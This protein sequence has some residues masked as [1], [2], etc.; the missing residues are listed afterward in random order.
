MKRKVVTLTKKYGFTVILVSIFFLGFLVRLYK[1]NTPLA[2]WHS[3]RQVDTASVTKILLEDGEVLRPKYLD[4]SKVQ[5]GYFNPQGLRFVEFPVFNIIHA[6]LYSLYPQLGIEVWGRL[7]SIFSAMLTSV[8]VFLIGKR[9]KNKWL[10]FFAATYYLL[11]PYNVYFTRVILPDPLSVMFAVSSVYFFWGYIDSKKLTPLYASSILFSLAVLTKPHAIFFAIP[12]AYLALKKFGVKKI[13]TN[14]PLLIAL[15]IALIPVFLWR[16][17]MGRPEH[18]AGIP[19][20]TWAFNGDGIR[21][22]P[23]FWRWIFGERIGKLILGIWGLIPFAVGLVTKSKSKMHYVLLFSAFLYLSVFATSNVRHDYYQLF[24]M[25][26]IVIVLALGTIS[27]LSS[28]HFE[29]IPSYTLY[30]I[31]LFLM[32]GIGLFSIRGNYNINDPNMIAAGQRADELLPKDARVIA[33]Y[34]GNTAFLYQVNRL[35]WPIV[36]N[37]IE[38]MMSIG[39]QYYVSTSLGDADTTKFREKFEVLEETDSYI[40]INLQ[41]SKQ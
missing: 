12:I 11:I 26:A 14:I 4:I 40:I 30:F 37:S 27:L 28:K 34:N 33:P 2:D 18:L 19:H 21:F 20:V 9:I 6:T 22:R 25:P 23:A 1:I 39:A 8:F 17:W 24:I 41:N 5:T 38:H 29:L 32:L 15:D 35:G 3:W 16:A 31:S 7:V 10:G 13:F 36:N